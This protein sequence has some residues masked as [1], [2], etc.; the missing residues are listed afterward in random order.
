MKNRP[1]NTL[2]SL[3]L[4]SVLSSSAMAEQDLW[5][6]MALKRD[7]ADIAKV[8]VLAKQFRAVDTSPD[9]LAQLLLNRS[10]TQFDIRLPMPDGSNALFRLQYSPVYQTSLEQR[11]PSIRTFSG[12]QLDNPDNRG[13]FDITPH[14]FHGMFMYNQQRA[15]IDPMARGNNVTH[16]SYYKKDAA[17]QSK[18]DYDQV[19]T[20]DYLPKAQSQHRH[21]SA[22]RAGETLKT[23]RIAVAAAGE[24]TE[25]HG[26]TKELAKAAIVTAINRV[27][28]VYNVDLSVQLNLVDNDAIIYTDATTD[29]YDNTSEDMNANEA[30]MTDNVGSGNYDIGHIFNTGGGGV[31]YLGVVCNDSAK[32]GGVTGSSSPTADPFVIDYVAHEVGHQFGG[33]HSFN[34]TAGN[35][36]TR[37][38][39]DA[40]EPGSGSTI[41]AYAGI[42]DD[43][44]LQN[45]SDAFF[46]SH[47]VEQMTSFITDSATCSVNTALNNEAPTVEAGSD[48]T[49]P[50]ST[51]FMLNG[52]ATDPEGD[53][54]SYSW[55]QFDTGPESTS[56]ETMVDDGERPLFRA[57]LP[58][59]STSR[60]LPRLSDVLKGETVIGETYPTTSRPMV[61][62]LMVRDGKGNVTSDTMTVTSNTGAG[63]FTVTSPSA[64]DTWSN[65]GTPAVEWN[66]ANTD[67]TPVS[68]ANVDIMLSTDSGETFTTTVLA[69]TPNDGAQ[70]VTVPSV[71]TTTARLMV[72]CSDNI[73]YAVN[74]GGTF[75]IN[76]IAGDAPTITGQVELS[77]DEDNSLTVNLTDLTVDDSDNNFPADFTMTL[78]AGD[79]YTVEGNVVTP[80][81]NYNGSLTVPVKVND[82]QNDSNTFNLSVTV[83]AVND[84]PVITSAGLLST[85]ED[86]ALT[87]DLSALTIS[88]PDSNAG[89]M[90]LMLSGGDN[91]TLD[92]NVLMPAENYHGTLAV[93]AKV[94]DGQADSNEVVLSVTVNSVNDNPV[95]TDDA[96]TVGQDTSGNAFDLLANDTDVDGDTLTISAATTSN[97]GT[98]EITSTGVNYTPAS[99]FSGTETISYTVSDGNGGSADATATIT[100]TATTTPDT[101][102][103]TGGSTSG[104]GGGSMPLTLTLLLAPL[105]MIR[106]KKGLKS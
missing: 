82:G 24:Y 66:V 4:L 96:Y 47:S 13:R 10:Q 16:I 105:A 84:A 88:D 76:G 45:N 62:K 34:G 50:V 15:F 35:C 81:A 57:W 63:P 95:A 97:G 22:Q 78:S 41:M 38:N 89:S 9:Q 25:F 23:Y 54:L 80:A 11:Y 93:M 3:G 36:G 100:V 56:K 5:R 71:D 51:P 44:N 103:D 60:Y 65:G 7:L 59:S 106:R 18:P 29:P 86:T 48:Y 46:H 99:G 27:N 53:T 2:F 94:N 32:W 40:Y 55:E 104:G 19:V 21:Q 42:C 102:G 101:G 8:N 87:I 6:D 12:Y 75:T 64:G 31:A 68:C 33:Q 77:V 30:V 1:W 73:F 58:T 43:Q 79:N 98:A 17:P 14:G 26:G 20:H 90:T 83:N 74:T 85:D 72:K 70:T 67:Q 49:I 52:S 61:F 39:D 91:Y 28:E 37:S 92:G 69:G